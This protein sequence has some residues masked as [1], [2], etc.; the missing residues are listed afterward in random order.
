[1]NSWKC[2]GFWIVY[3][4]NSLFLGFEEIV[5]KFVWVFVVGLKCRICGFGFCEMFENIVMFNGGLWLG[6]WSEVDLCLVYFVI[7]RVDLK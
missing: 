3:F 2:V 6:M 7:G 5:C 1:M 4:L